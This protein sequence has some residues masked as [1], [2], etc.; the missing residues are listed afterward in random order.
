MVGLKTTSVSPEE[1]P[2]A[3]KKKVRKRLL[4]RPTGRY[5]TFEA[6][7]EGGGEVPE[8]LLGDYTSVDSAQRAIDLYLAQRKR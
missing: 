8:S 3:V 2:K 5:A 4:V 6:H 1:A 7:Y